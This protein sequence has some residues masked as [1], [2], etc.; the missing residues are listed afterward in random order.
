[1]RQF[2][3]QMAGTS[4]AGKTTL[5][6]AIGRATGAVVVDKDIIKAQHARWGRLPKK[7]PAV[8]PTRSSSTSASSL[9][10]QGFNV[11]MDSPAFFDAHP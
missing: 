2:L 8:R 10:A 1:M 9:L 11:V 3:L 7:L 5:A 4:A 6:F